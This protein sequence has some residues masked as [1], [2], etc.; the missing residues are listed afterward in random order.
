MRTCRLF[1]VFFVT[2]CLLTSSQT[3]MAERKN[4]SCGRSLA[5]YGAIA[6]LLTVPAGLLLSN[7]FDPEIPDD[8]RPEGQGNAPLRAEDPE[9]AGA[10]RAFWGWSSRDFPAGWPRLFSVASA[11]LQ[12]R[13]TGM[14]LA[15]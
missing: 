3:A 4:K 11:R 12:P 13:P 8:W 6:L 1:A 7:I 14:P 9:S 15:R 2:L 5:R 10:L